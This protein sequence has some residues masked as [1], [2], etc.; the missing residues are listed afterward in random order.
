DGTTQE[1]A[2]LESYEVIHKD[3]MRWQRSLSELDLEVS[4][5]DQAIASAQAEA[6]RLESELAIVSL[7]LAELDVMLHTSSVSEI[8]RLQVE[9]RSLVKVS[10][11]LRD[12]IDV[13]LRAIG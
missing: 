1:I 2:T 4:R 9:Q 13:R 12:L 10:D 6:A 5:K 3:F 7:R 8:K 11:D